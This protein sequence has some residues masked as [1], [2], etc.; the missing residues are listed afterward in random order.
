MESHFFYKCQKLEFKFLFLARKKTTELS[1][2]LS[3]MIVGG[4]I[5]VLVFCW[6]YIMTVVKGIDFVGT[7]LR[8]MIPVVVY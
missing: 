2:I 7:V 3:K 6:R 5:E 8:Y 4:V 1:K